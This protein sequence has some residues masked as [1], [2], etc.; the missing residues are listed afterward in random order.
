MTKSG[1][2][3]I[4]LPKEWALRNRIHRGSIVVSLITPDDKII[5]DPKYTAEPISREIVLKPGPYLSRN[6]VG[7]YLLGYDLIKI[8]AKDR[9]TPE[10]RD[11]IKQTSSQLVGLEIIEENQSKIVMQCLLEPS[12][13]S[14]E[15]ILRR[16]HLITLSMCKDS[17]AALLERDIHLARNVI[18]RDNEVDRLYFLLVR[19]LRT[20]I[21]NPSLSEKL[22]IRPIDCLDYRLVASFIELVADQSSQIAKYAIRFR[23]VKLADEIS[24][25]LGELHKLVLGTYDDAVISFLSHNV[26]IA[27]SVREK[28]PSV[29]EL[30]S[31]V[32]TLSS[33]ISFE[34][35]QDLVMVL[36]LLNRIYDYSIDIS[37][38]TTSRES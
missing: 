36:S 15:K 28:E 35:S 5:I 6:I 32:E 17:I 27:V 37:D 11:V 23:D 7:S 31:R 30:I 25:T 9:I 34:R 21:Q 8:E 2:Y 22:N 12:A 14:P 26:P 33:T 13:L 24:E 1:T 19:V 4:T 3:F 20:I 18:A 10:Q 38:L 29:R 16:E